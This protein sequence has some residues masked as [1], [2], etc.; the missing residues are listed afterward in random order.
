MTP[1]IS[2]GSIYKPCRPCLRPNIYILKITSLTHCHEN[3]RHETGQMGHMPPP[4]KKKYRENMF[5]AN[6]I[7]TP[8]I[9]GQISCK[10]RAF[11]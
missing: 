9:F 4:P 6:V 5:R 11:S 1:G 3:I 2:R 10:I 8:D 7:K